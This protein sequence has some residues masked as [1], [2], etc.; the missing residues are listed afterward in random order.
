MN[1]GLLQANYVVGTVYVAEG[2]LSL[3]KCSSEGRQ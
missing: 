1:P 2:K 3:S